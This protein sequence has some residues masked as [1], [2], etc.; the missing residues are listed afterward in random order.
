MAATGIIDLAKKI[1]NAAQ[2]IHVFSVANNVPL[3]HGS[4]APDPASVSATNAAAYH[5][6]C[7][8]ASEA[9]TEMK[10][11]ISGNQTMLLDIL[12]NV[13]AASALR[14]VIRYGIVKAVPLHGSI[15]YKKLAAKCGLDATTVQRILGVLM[16]YHIF[17][18]PQLGHVAHTR[19][20][21]SI[22]TDEG[23]AANTRFHFEDQASYSYHIVEAL[24]RWGPSPEGTETAFNIVH[25]TVLNLYDYMAQNR[26]YETKFMKVMDHISSSEMTNIDMVFDGFDWEAVGNGVVF[27]VAGSAGHVSVQ[28]AR[29]YPN[30]SFVVQDYESVCQQGEAQLPV[31][32]KDRVR[33]EARDMFEPHLRVPDKKAVYFLRNVLH[34]WS[35]KYSR[36]I[37]Q[38]IVPALKEGDRIVLNE[39]IVPEPGTGSA[40]VE[41]FARASDMTMLSILNGQERTA[42]QFEA[43]VESADPGL[44]VVA[45]KTAHALTHGVIEIS[46]IKK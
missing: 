26:E 25:G 3:S 21:K 28:L 40:T 15:T 35:D 20:S 17:T 7:L 45:I 32:V 1:T 39:H 4:S 13:H 16:G 33:F 44:K 23:F 5:E 22:A 43:L 24:E 18:Q 31:D 2:V 41:R 27:D 9:L 29:R 11:L 30:L 34:N 38:A 37:L 46:Y 6:A 12:S 10:A 8:V 19:I 42:Q 14:V 36:K